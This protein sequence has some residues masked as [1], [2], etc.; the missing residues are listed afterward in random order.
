[1]R[2]TAN[3]HILWGRCLSLMAF[4][5]LSIEKFT[6]CKAERLLQETDTAVLS[7]GGFR[8]RFLP[9]ANITIITFYNCGTLPHC[10]TV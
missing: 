10:V 1:M 3:V 5:K 8:R 4:L 9:R 7:E 6:V 2:M